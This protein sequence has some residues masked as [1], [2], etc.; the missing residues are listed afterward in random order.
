[1]DDSC[2]SPTPMVIATM[3]RDA[4]ANDLQAFNRRFPQPIRQGEDHYDEYMD[5]WEAM[6]K[7]AGIQQHSQTLNYVLLHATKQ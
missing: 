3:Q 2:R 1:M 7:K 6:E 4:V 5:Q